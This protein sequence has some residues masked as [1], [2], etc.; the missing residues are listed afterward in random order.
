[1]DNGMP[2]ARCSHT[3]THCSHYYPECQPELAPATNMTLKVIYCFYSTTFLEKYG[4]TMVSLVKKKY[5]F[6]GTL[7]PKILSSFTHPQVVANLSFFLLLN[8]KEDVLKNDWN[9][10]TIDFHSR[11][12]KILW[13]SMMPKFQ[14]PKSCCL[15]RV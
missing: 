12:K 6:K 10:G 9:F 1:M 11:K 14:S 2:Q 4:F 15:F 8:T 13:K 5:T 7:H 3:E